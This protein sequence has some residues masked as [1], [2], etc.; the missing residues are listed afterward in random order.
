M[1]PQPQYLGSKYKHLEWIKQYIPKNIKVCADGFAGSQSV[2]YSFKQ[3]GYC[4]HTNDFMEYSNQIGKS[5]IENNSQILSNNDIDL[6]FSEN[7]N[8]SKYCLVETLYTNLFFNKADVRFLDSF[9]SHIDELNEYKQNLALTI[10]LRAMTRKVPLGHFAHT[11]TMEYS[12]NTERIKRN[13]SL[14]KPI[15]DIFLELVDKYNQA[16]FDNGQNNKS[17]CLGVLEFVKKIENIDLIYFDPPYCDSH[18]DYQGFYHVLETYV[19]YWTDKTFINKTKRY[20]PKKY[21]GFDLKADIIRSLECL[22]EY[23][24]KIPYWI[25]SYNNKSY[26]TK[27][28]LVDLIKQYRDVEIV[29]KM[30]YNSVGG[31][32]STK[33]S[34][35]LLFICKPKGSNV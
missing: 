9:R 21:S 6:L 18:A 24:D 3:L 29:D 10:M 27:E 1:F 25:L 23:S 13:K 4:V 17:Y 15:K 30:Y 11:K 28:V 22:F 32:G 31:K 8:K 12:S 20:S 35:E 2:A 19:Q 5:L 16:V 34:K 33:G 14:I 26:P 7:T